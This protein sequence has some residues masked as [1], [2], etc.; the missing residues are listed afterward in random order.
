MPRRIVDRR[1]RQR[2]RTLC[3]YAEAYVSRM[4]TVLDQ[5]LDA[6]YERL[7]ASEQIDGVTIEA[8]RAL[9]QS[10]KKLTA[11]DF[12]AILESAPKEDPQ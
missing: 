12:V 7:G 8:L 6:F 3:G 4:T 2:A 1:I 10:G 5:I 11:N 9:F